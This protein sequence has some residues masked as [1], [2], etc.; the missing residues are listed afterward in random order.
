M[1]SLVSFSSLAAIDGALV[2]LL[3]PE[4][5]SS[6][7]SRNMQTALLSNNFLAEVLASDPSEENIAN[8]ISPIVSGLRLAV[9]KAGREMGPFHA[10]LEIF[11]N[12]I[13]IKVQFHPS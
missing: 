9:L 10:Y 11:M 4:S 2:P 7:T 3:V 12:L 8:I 1:R 6:K 5:P 13:S